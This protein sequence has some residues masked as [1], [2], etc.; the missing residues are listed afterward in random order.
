MNLV[1]NTVEVYREL[2]RKPSGEWGYASC[3]V[4]LPLEE[5]EVS[6]VGGVR[7]LSNRVFPPMSLG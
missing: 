2:L 4:K 3:R 7:L 5:L 6:G 1:D